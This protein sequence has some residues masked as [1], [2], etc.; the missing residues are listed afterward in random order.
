MLIS[1][2]YFYHIS[3]S[4]FQLASQK[5]RYLLDDPRFFTLCQVSVHL[6]EASKEIW[7]LH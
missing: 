1:E 3:D 6:L 5:Q 4:F 7:S 2:G